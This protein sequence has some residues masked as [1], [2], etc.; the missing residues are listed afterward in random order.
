MSTRQFVTC[1]GGT[2]EGGIPKMIP[3]ERRR[4]PAAPPLTFAL[5]LAIVATEVFEEL[6]N[7]R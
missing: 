7:W 2:V 6:V 1:P 5:R 3:N 4:R